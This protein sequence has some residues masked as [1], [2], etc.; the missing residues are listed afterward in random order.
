VTSTG[1]KVA[2]LTAANF[3]AQAILRNALEAAIEGIVIGVVQR[4]S[5]GNEVIASI[6]PS[7]DTAAQRESKWLVDYHDTTSLKRYS[8]EIGTADPDQLDAQDRA[9]AE[10]G[11]EDVVDAFITA[12]EAYVLSPTGGA[13]VVDE[14][15]WVGRNV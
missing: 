10:I 5:L 15:T 6:S 7:S 13:V 11:D 4:Q 2:A 8:V 9:H 3:D 1:V 12:F 14:I